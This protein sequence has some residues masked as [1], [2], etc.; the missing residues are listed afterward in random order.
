MNF[1]QVVKKLVLCDVGLVAVAVVA[2]VA[3][4]HFVGPGVPGACLQ[5]AVPPLLVPGVNVVVHALFAVGADDVLAGFHSN[6]GRVDLVDA[7]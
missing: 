1:L 6:A 2:V 5:V 7:P 3:K 4:V